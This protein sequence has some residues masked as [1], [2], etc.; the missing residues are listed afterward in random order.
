MESD[1]GI[2]DLLH[3][4]TSREKHFGNVSVRDESMLLIMKF[5][6]TGTS[7]FDLTLPFMVVKSNVVSSPLTLREF[8][9]CFITK[10]VFDCV[11]SIA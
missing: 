9:N 10:C 6:I 11:S 7:D 4:M 5:V 3:G 1:V 8:S 2:H